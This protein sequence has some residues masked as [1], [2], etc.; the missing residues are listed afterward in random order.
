MPAQALL[1]ALAAATDCALAEQHPAPGAGPRPR[2]EGAGCRHAA[3]CYC[4]ACNRVLCAAC[5]LEAHSMRVFEHHRSGATAG[6]GL[7]LGAGASTSTGARD[8]VVPWELHEAAAPRCAQHRMP[9]TRYDR[10]RVCLC[11][12]VC[13]QDDAARARRLVPATDAP[14]DVY[15]HLFCA[16]AALSAAIAELQAYLHRMSARLRYLDS[17]KTDSLKNLIGI[18]SFLRHEEEE[19]Q[20]EKEKQQEQQQQQEGQQK[21]TTTMA[22]ATMGKQQH[23]QPTSREKMKR[24]LR[25]CLSYP[26]TSRVLQETMRA[27]ATDVLLSALVVHREALLLKAHLWHSKFSLEQYLEVVHLC[28]RH[29]AACVLVRR[30]AVPATQMFAFDALPPALLRRAPALQAPLV[31]VP[32][33][34]APRLVAASRITPTH[35]VARAV[36][37]AAPAPRQPFFWTQLAFCHDASFQVILTPQSSA[38]SQ[39]TSNSG[40]DEE[41]KENNESSAMFFVPTVPQVT[42]AGEVRRCAALRLTGLHPG[43]TYTLVARTLVDRNQACSEYSRPLVFT[44]PPE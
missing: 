38:S 15:H 31:C 12:E 25:G 17:V 27:T 24:L 13:A 32:D 16:L 10:R 22:T 44:T 7:G 39:T 8:C 4:S 14:M 9:L 5:E 21:Q 6:A 36:A 1:P 40:S 43:T 30:A 18:Y 11:C 29:A 20:E 41:K 37:A 23:Q 2:C 42:D 19:E 3:E 26:Q 28:R 35:L 34:P 33:I